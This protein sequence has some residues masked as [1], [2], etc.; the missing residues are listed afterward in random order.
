MRVMGFKISM[1][2]CGRSYSSHKKNQIIISQ[3]WG[4][5]RLGL[6]GDLF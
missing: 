2:G 3:R 5:G 6:G 4:G 1:D